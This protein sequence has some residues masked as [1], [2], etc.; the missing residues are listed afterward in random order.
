MYVDY[1]LG[2]LY[3]VDVASI[4]DISE[5]MLCEAEMNGPTMGECSCINRIWS[6]IP[7]GRRV[8]ADVPITDY[9]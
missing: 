5:I 4:V 6:K 1:A 7:I 9:N 3:R 2:S 8:E